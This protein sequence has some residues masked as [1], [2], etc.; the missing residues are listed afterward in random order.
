MSELE[1]ATAAEANEFIA[2]QL[3]WLKD[4]KKAQPVQL[5]PG[6][7]P[8]AVKADSERWSQMIFRAEADP[9]AAA[10]VA[11]FALPAQA[12]RPDL[13][14]RRWHLDKLA[15]ECWEARTSLFVLSE[16][17][18]DIATDA[19]R[20]QAELERVAS[21]LFTAPVKLEPRAPSSAEGPLAFSTNPVTSLLTT[22]SWSARVDAGVH[23]KQLFFVIQKRNPQ[24]VGAGSN[25]WFPDQFKSALQARAKP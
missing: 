4:A 24:L 9:L 1:E 3:G 21:A 12:Q 5:T 13:L 17:P 15:L 14:L 2:F 22:P 19:P 23:D 11:F 10:D 25:V 20:V 16:L 6:E 8:P 7:L 18:P